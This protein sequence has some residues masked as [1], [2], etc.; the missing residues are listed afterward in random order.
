MIHQQNQVSLKILFYQIS[1][2]KY[3]LSQRYSEDPSPEQKAIDF[4][5]LQDAIISTIT[6]VMAEDELVFEEK[7]I[8]EH[9]LEL[10]VA[11][12]KHK[13]SLFDSFANS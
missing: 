9:A 12:L 5:K 7:L 1:I 4:S 13:P 10:W 6:S 3:F 2:L 8:V 11:C